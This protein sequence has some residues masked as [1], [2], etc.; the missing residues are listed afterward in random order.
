MTLINQ[1]LNDL[2]SSKLKFE[3]NNL[4][5]ITFTGINK[6]DYINNLVTS[7]SKIN[8][9]TSKE[10]TTNE[11]TTKGSNSKDTINLIKFLNI[12]ETLAWLSIQEEKGCYKCASFFDKKQIPE[13]KSIYNIIDK[14]TLP[15]YNYLIDNQVKKII[16]IYDNNDNNKNML[17]FCKHTHPT[18]V[19]KEFIKAVEIEPEVNNNESNAKHHNDRS[20][21]QI[22]TNDKEKLLNEELYYLSECLYP[23]FNNV[24]ISSGLKFSNFMK[25]LYFLNDI[26]NEIKYWQNDKSNNCF[27]CNY[28][29]SIINM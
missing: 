26:S 24:N 20:S 18:D 14:V 12:C 2:K 5:N 4:I 19:C 9:D 1:I 29:E 17:I 16:K 22:N 21:I 25:E 27:P 6:E 8:D 7:F 10:G 28:I 3:N 13:P 23:Y 11:G 15:N